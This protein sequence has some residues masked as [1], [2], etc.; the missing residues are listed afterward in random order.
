M[1]PSVIDLLLQAKLAA[2]AGCDSFFWW[3]GGDGNI[4]VALC[5]SVNATRPDGFD[6]NIFTFRVE[7]RFVHPERTTLC[8]S[9]YPCPKSFVYVFS[10]EVEFS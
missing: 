9:N 6:V 7:E 3:N 2:A 4:I 10:H 8:F 5:T 1:K